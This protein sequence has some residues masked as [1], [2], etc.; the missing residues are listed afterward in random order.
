MRTRGADV[1]AP[2]RRVPVPPVAVGLERAAEALDMSATAFRE[3]VAPE[4]RWVRRGRMKR[5]A[6]AELVRW[7]ERNQERVPP[8]EVAEGER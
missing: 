4:V 3:Q 5:V 8:A 7:V 2:K 6:V 1:S